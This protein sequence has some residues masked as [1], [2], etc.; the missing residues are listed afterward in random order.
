MTT[1]KDVSAKLKAAIK[2]KSLKFGVSDSKESS[3]GKH[4]ATIRISF[5][6]ETGLKKAAVNVYLRDDSPSQSDGYEEISL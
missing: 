4:Y 5:P 3:G 2:A 6:A 1:K